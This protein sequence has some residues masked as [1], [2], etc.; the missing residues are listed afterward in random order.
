[1]Q[2][3]EASIESLVSLLSPTLAKQRKDQEKGHASLLTG[4]IDCFL[5]LSQVFQKA[6]ALCDL[7][8]VTIVAS[9]GV[10]CP[11]SDG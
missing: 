8:C 9:G 11:L 6:P 3:G 5:M 1:P 7:P 2:N 10:S 4:K